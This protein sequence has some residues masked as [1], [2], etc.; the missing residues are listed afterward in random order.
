M[1]L[2]IPCRRT[3]SIANI[4]NY[5]AL[6]LDS[7]GPLPGMLSGQE[8][9]KL[10]FLRFLQRDAL[11][12]DIGVGRPQSLDESRTFRDLGSSQGAEGMLR[13]YFLGK[14]HENLLGRHVGDEM[15]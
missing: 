4:V 3:Y 8:W 6:S 10:C 7:G 1:K 14:R 11:E 9:N 12:L 5:K 2:V 13:S 15:A